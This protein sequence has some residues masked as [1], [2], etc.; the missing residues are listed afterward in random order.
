M[1]QQ[2]VVHACVQLDII[3]MVMETATAA[4]TDAIHAAQMIQM[5]VLHVDLMLL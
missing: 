4:S 5:P 1:L 2:T 3:W